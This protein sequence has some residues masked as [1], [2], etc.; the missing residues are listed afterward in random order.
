MKPQADPQ[1]KA[2]MKLITLLMAGLFAYAF[3]ISDHTFKVYLIHLSLHKPL[4]LIGGALLMGLVLGAIGGIGY[5]IYKSGSPRD[6][7]ESV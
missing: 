4:Q 7:A 2:W 6:K 1:F 5:R 3:L